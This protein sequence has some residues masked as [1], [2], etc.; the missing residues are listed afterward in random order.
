MPTLDFLQKGK[1]TAS[2]GPRGSKKSKIRDGRTGLYHEEYFNEIL[3]FEK[4]RCERSRDSVLLMCADL[5]AFGEQS[6]RQKIAALVMHTLSQV[7]RE[8]DLKG[9]YV[10]GT[11]VGILFTQLKEQ[12]KDRKTTAQRIINKFSRS[13]AASS[14]LERLSKINISWRAYPDE[15]LDASAD[16]R[17]DSRRGTGRGDAGKGGRLSL[18][19]KRLIDVVSSLFAMIFLSPA[20]LVIAV[21]IKLNSEGPVFFRQERVGLAGKRFVF[22]KFRSMYVDNDPEIHKAYVAGLI[23]AGRE[24]EGKDANGS[25]HTY[26]ITDDPRITSL[27][28][29]LR[30]SSMD[31]LPQLIN[32]L[33]G[34]MSLVGPRPAIPY[35]CQNY[36]V[37]HRRRVME[38]KPGITGLWQ[39][40]GRS[41]L[42]FD[43]SVRLDIRYVQK[44]SLW[45]DLKI[46]FR[47]P[48]AVASCRGAY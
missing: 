38:M 29:I 22:L 3:A 23:R 2:G 20:F 1:A 41:A 13:L 37:W 12:G 36:D 15:F 31:E 30:K 19:T 11:V 27:G 8:T 6:E 43:E 46:I 25:G 5:D 44:W 7:T 32:V 42:P 45:L 14:D 9:W 24:S 33:R 28:R 10:S 17:S 4:R 18:L 39:V 48:F 40:E 47:T 35:E 21:L 34:H 26:K 16:P